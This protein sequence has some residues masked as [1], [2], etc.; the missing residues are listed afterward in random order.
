MKKQAIGAIALTLLAGLSINSPM[1][2]EPK[3]TTHFAD[4]GVAYVVPVRKP[5]NT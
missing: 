1:A 4:T 5:S 2:S 3:V